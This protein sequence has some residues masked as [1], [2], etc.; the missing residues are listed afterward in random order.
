MDQALTGEAGA[1][2]QISDALLSYAR[3]IDRLDGDLVRAAFHPTAMLHDYG[4]DQPMSISDFVQYAIPRLGEGY[5]ATQHRISNT[6]VDFGE[7]G[8]PSGVARVETYVLAFHVRSGQPGPDHL[9]TFN[10]R[11]IDDFAEVEGQWRIRRRR[12]RHDW[13][14]SEVI[15]DTMGGAWVDS[16][17][18]RSDAVFAR[19]APR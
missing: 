4:S 11:Y 8:H 17:R 6:H 1:R 3:G 16:A 14:K 18:D 13:S 10:G 12:L 9:L 2:Q 15:E 5:T 7:G 19:L